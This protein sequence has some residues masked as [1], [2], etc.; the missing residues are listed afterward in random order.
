[1]N[2]I[3]YFGRIFAIMALGLVLSEPA[4]AA[5]D[6]NDPPILKTGTFDDDFFAGGDTVV[7]NVNQEQDLYVAGGEVQV[8]APVIGD[9][10]AVGGEMNLVGPI[11]GSLL[12]VGGKFHAS[13]AIGS[14]AVVFGGE[15]T[16]DS[17]IAGDGLFLGAKIDVNRR[18]AGNLRAGGGKVMLDSAVDGNAL[19]GGGRVDL[20]PGAIV[21]GKAT[22]AGGLVRIDGHIGQG[23]RAVADTIIIAGEIG[24][25]ANLRANE[26]IIL[27]T[28]RIAGDLIYY[29][30]QP[31]ELSDKVTIGGD[32]AFIQS[33]ALHEGKEDFLAFTGGIHFIW[34][35][36]LILAVAAVIFAAPQ[37]LPSLNAQMKTTRWTSLWIGFATLIGGPVIIVL[38]VGT[39][40]GLPLALILTT[41]YTLVLAIGYFASAFALGRKCQLWLKRQPE[42][43]FKGQFLS[44]AIGLV[45]LGFALVIPVVGVL[46][47]I[48]ATTLGLS[49]MF[50]A[51]AARR[52]TV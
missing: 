32:V 4:G 10:F 41:L 27:D 18:V 8:N 5:R 49:V 45:V 1:M 52:K 51:F 21:L 17:E 46:A 3:K 19:L 34:I 22:L 43:S 38:L 24:G 11:N 16:V 28:A 31:I 29:S 9:V 48:I 20:G 47:N 2:R 30:P 6:K 13:G 7:I 36:G 25:D 23:L 40:F 35:S 15:L 50:L 12:A 42:T 33:G 26:I 39:V 14:D 44:A 37:L